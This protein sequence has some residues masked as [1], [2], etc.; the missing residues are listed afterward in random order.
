MPIPNPRSSSRPRRRRQTARAEGRCAVTASTATT[1]PAVTASAPPA[2]GAVAPA[3][4]KKKAKKKSA[5]KKSKKTG[6]ADAV[7]KP[8]KQAALKRSGARGESWPP[9]EIELDL[10]Q[11][12]RSRAVR[13]AATASAGDAAAAAAN[14]GGGE[15][16]KVRTRSYRCT[17]RRGPATGRQWRRLRLEPV[18]WRADLGPGSGAGPAD[19]VAGQCRAAEERHRSLRGDRGGRWLADGAES[20]DGRGLVRR[21]RRGAQKAPRDRGRPRQRQL[22]RRRLIRWR[23]RGRGPPLPGEKRSDR[24]PAIC[25]TS[26]SP[27]T[28]RG[29]STR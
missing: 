12:F 29:L 13:E 5:K 24:Q 15:T 23:A 25:S 10:W 4:T 22:L 6:V 16:K 3:V 9:T 17:R 1:A 11:Y 2:D 8:K 18:R 7:G 27:R 21:G 14:S 19:P 26:R 20:A 28:A